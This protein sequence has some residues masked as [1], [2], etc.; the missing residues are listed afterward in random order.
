MSV[1]TRLTHFLG[2]DGA[3]RM[4]SLVVDGSAFVLRRG[5]GVNSPMV[6]IRLSAEQLRDIAYLGERISPQAT[7]R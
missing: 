5:V 6:E 1:D 7:K 3:G 2:R 4:L